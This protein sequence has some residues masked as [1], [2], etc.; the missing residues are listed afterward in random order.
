MQEAQIGKYTF[1]KR[2]SS[3][4]EGLRDL[5][6]IYSKLL[7]YAENNRHE[8]IPDQLKWQTASLTKV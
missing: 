5:Y 2:L 8:D 4:K 1:E 7:K 6:N 3:K